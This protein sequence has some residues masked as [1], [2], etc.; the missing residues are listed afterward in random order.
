MTNPVHIYILLGFLI[1]TSIF[2]LYAVN[3]KQG[4]YY[5]VLQV[6]S[7]L[8]FLFANISE[9]LLLIYRYWRGLSERNYIFANNYEYLLLLIILRNKHG[10]VFIK[11]GQGEQSTSAAQD[12]ENENREAKN[13]L[14]DVLK[15]VEDLEKKEV[16]QKLDSGGG[17]S[18]PKE[19][20]DTVTDIQNRFPSFFDEDSGN[21][22]DKKQGYADLKEYLKEEIKALPMPESSK[23]EVAIDRDSKKLKDSS[24]EPSKPS[25]SLEESVVKPSEDTS[26][27]SN[28]KA[29]SSESS[30]PS[31]SKEESGV[32]PESSENKPKGSL[33]DDFA[34]PNNEPA[35]WFGG[36]D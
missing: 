15:K 22:D 9:Y 18:I 6:T 12:K 29:S 7:S 4:P 2:I 17:N 19:D 11:R 23:D 21:V 36:D 32:K 20:W 13:V 24:S 14:S 31:T 16:P 30:K 34:N 35:D 8:I 28:K 25:T 1:V 5:D 10:L 33:I 26:S 3:S 27:D